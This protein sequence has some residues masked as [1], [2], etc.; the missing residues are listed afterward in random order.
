MILHHVRCATARRRS[1]KKGSP[2]REDVP[3]KSKDVPPKRDHQ[4]KR[5]DV[6][7]KKTRTYHQK[8]IAKKKL[9]S[10]QKLILTC[11]KQFAS[12][13]TKKGPLASKQT[14]ESAGK[15][16]KESAGRTLATRSMV[17]AAQTS[18][19]F[20]L[21]D[22]ELRRIRRPGTSKRGGAQLDHVQQVEFRFSV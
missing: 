8:G 6:P 18:V 5:E 10:P 2:K 1:K 20:P 4:R 21:A 17:P 15:Q 7:P 22:F 12:K 13:Q 14:K 11:Y 9:G 19:S 16:T 3:P